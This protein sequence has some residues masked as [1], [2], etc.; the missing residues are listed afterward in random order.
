MDSPIADITL[1]NVIEAIQPHWTVRTDTAERMAR[2]LSRIFTYAEVKKLRIGDPADQKYLSHV[3]PQKGK[4]APVKHREAMD[5]RD[6]PALYK[7]LS[8]SDTASAKA[9]QWVMLSAC[10]SAEGRKMTWGEID[11]EKQVWTMHAD[12]T[13]QRRAFTAP[14]TNEMA[15]IIQWASPIQRSEYVITLTGTPLSDVA[16]AKLL[17][18][19][20][21]Q[22]NTVHGLRTSFRTWCQETG[23]EEV[24]SEYCLN[25]V[26]GSKV[27]RAYAR[28]DMLEE[29][30]R[31][32][33]DW[34]DFLTSGVCN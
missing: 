7:T 16:I 27:R 8:G 33:T 25:H 20:T 13:K 1:D 18:R 6:C 15:K 29:R 3:L 12:R 24:I 2:K 26:V 23:V 10:R 19:H 34:A 31:V 28:S 17:K 9:L 11:L 21:F 4:I 14:I 30:T 22:N 5:Y 32:M